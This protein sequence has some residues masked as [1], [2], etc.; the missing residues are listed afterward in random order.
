MKAPAAI[1]TNVVVAGLLTHPAEVSTARILDGMLPAAFPFAVSTALLAEYR[2][3]PGRAKLRRLHGLSVADV[4]TLVVELVQHAIVLQAV[5]V[6]SQGPHFHPPTIPGL[7][8]PHSHGEIHDPTAPT[9]TEMD[10][11]LVVYDFSRVGP[12]RGAASAR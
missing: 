11:L 9:L 6:R 1:D 8:P 5:G 7:M 2:D 10:Y 3:V 12:G 4:E